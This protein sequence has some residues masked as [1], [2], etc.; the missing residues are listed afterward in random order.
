MQLIALSPNVSVDEEIY[1]EMVETE[2]EWLW[3]IQMHKH[4]AGDPVFPYLRKRMFL[5][6]IERGWVFEAPRPPE[7]LQLF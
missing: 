7:Q 3:A 2:T 1:A 6:W 5:S 4:R